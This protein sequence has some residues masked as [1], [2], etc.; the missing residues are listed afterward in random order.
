MDVK[1]LASMV[2]ILNLLGLCVSGMYIVVMGE[3]EDVVGCVLAYTKC[4]KCDKCLYIKLS[5]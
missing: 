3:V 2:F 1:C 5:I 4:D